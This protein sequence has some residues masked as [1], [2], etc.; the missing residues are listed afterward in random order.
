MKKTLLNIFYNAIYQI[1]LVI[2][3][4][5]TVPY[6]SRNLGPNAYGIYGSVNNTVQFLMVFC[7]L[8]VSYTGMRTISFTHARSTREELSRAF[9][10]L[11]YFQAI[12]SFVMILGTVILAITLKFQYCNFIL[13]I[14]KFMLSDQFDVL[15]V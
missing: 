1:F 9:W 2:V 10:G 5:V 8:S 4:L 6:L 3:P 15:L 13:L 14:L 11:W 12:A 7:Y